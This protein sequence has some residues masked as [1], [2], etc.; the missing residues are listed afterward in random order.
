MFPF[1]HMFTEQSAC[2]QVIDWMG[3]ARFDLIARLVRLVHSTQRLV[4]SSGLKG[5]PDL[6]ISKVIRSS[7]M[8]SSIGHFPRPTSY[9]VAKI[10]NT[11][12]T[13]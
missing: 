2:S 1:H 13:S 9:Y 4:A 12:G 3:I 8:Q 6:Q 10:V 11:A 5:S 7:S